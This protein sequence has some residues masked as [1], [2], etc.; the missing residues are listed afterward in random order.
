MP[1]FRRF[2]QRFLAGGA[3]RSIDDV[4]LVS[5][6][7]TGIKPPDRLNIPLLV[8]DKPWSVVRLHT[9]FR[10]LDRNPGELSDREARYARHCLSS[11]WLA[12]PV[13]QL[14]ALYATGLGELQRAILASALCGAP[15]ASDE[16]LWRDRLA[17]RLSD[18]H[19][20]PE[21]TNLL[22]AAMPY[23]APEAL[24]I[25]DPLQ[26]V[27]QWL[28]AD[29]ASHCEPALQAR[30]RGPAGLLA[31]SLDAQP[32]QVPLVE[33][34]EVPVAP[35][36]TAPLPIHSEAAEEPDGL[37]LPTLSRREP[38]DAM[39]LFSSEA[40]VNRMAALINLFSI[41]PEDAETH[42]ELAGLRRI[43]GQLW[44]NVEP[45][46]MEALY[47]SG[48]GTVYRSLLTC[49]FGAVPLN[50]RDLEA[51]AQLVP[52]VQDL[53]RQKALNALLAVLPF[54]A[55]GKIRLAGGEEHLPA[56][57]IAELARLTGVEGS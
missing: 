55:P 41:D 1:S 2:L 35:P 12:V 24:R 4:D 11:F 44:L 33:E 8:R 7:G 25:A 23:F 19:N 28:L 39:A 36:A 57:L 47:R 26:R 51:R 10:D 34:P 15:L 40:A 17:Q 42:K 38:A 48:V 46:S 29:Y 32:P 20:R 50:E 13:D 18:D 14:E 21:R 6:G 9:I 54:F 43:I 16:F 49:G 3:P 37:T 52:W 22:L 53:S 30:L 27:P 5:I 31:S 45:Q 56:W